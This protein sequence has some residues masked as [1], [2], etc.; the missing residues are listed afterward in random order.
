MSSLRAALP[1]SRIIVVDHHSVDTSV[2]IAK[3]YGAEIH[4][5]GVG[6]GWARQLCIDMVDTPYFAFVDSDVEV[7]DPRF[8][9]RALELLGNPSVGAVVGM[10]K[11]HRLAFGL[12]A[13]LLVLRRADFQGKVIPPWIDARETFY[14]QKRL[15]QLGLKTVYVYDAMIHRSQ[16]RLYKP[17]WEGANTRL[18][19]TNPLRELLF[20]LGVIILISLNSRNIKNIAYIPI[21][22]LKFLRGFAHP[23]RWVK[24]DRRSA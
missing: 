19:E 2:S 3:K 13:S 8:F 15:D 4:F 9:C 5:E 23:A 11:G 12:P 7:T 17:E 22:Y 14:I 6:L 21:F 1:R 10:S 24:L 20:S 16:Y 18:L